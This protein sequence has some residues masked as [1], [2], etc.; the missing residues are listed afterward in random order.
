MNLLP[1]ALPH[2]VRATLAAPPVRHTDPP[3]PAPVTF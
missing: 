2:P 1:A 3:R